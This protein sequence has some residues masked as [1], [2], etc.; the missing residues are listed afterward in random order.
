MSW[1]WVKYNGPTQLG[2][3]ITLHLIELWQV[4]ANAKQHKAEGLIVLMV[5]TTVPAYTLNTQQ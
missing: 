5:L 2:C 4:V 3:D 1:V